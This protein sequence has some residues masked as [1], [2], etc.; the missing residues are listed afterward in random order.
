MLNRKMKVFM[1]N[2]YFETF[3]LQTRNNQ[4]FSLGKNVCI[5]IS[6]D[7]KVLLHIEAEISVTFSDE[8]AV[9]VHS[10]HFIMYCVTARVEKQS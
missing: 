2:S 8:M 4:Y 6:L 3:P 5:C 9:R 1:R 10:L 7:G